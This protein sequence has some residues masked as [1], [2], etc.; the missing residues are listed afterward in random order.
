[1]CEISSSGHVIFVGRIVLHDP[2][3]LSLFIMYVLV[4]GSVNELGS[5]KSIV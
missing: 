4:P 3:S 5:V 2:Y 1:M